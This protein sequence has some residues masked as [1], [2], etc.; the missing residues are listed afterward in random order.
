MIDNFGELYEKCTEEEKKQI[1]NTL[2]EKIEVYP[3]PMADGRVIKSVSFNFPVYLGDEEGKE[4]FLSKGNNV[5]S[6]CLLSK[7]NTRDGSTR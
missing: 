6:V 2:I 7:A 4:V 1:I 3:E 5:E